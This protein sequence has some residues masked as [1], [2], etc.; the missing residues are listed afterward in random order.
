MREIPKYRRKRVG[1]N[2]K[3]LRKMPGALKTPAIPKAL[4]R[5]PHGAL[6]AQTE[7]ETETEGKQKPKGGCGGKTKTA[8]AG[9]RDRFARFW[10]AYPKKR[11]KGQAERAFFRIDPDEQFLATMIATI[12]RATTSEEWLKEGGKFIPYPATWLGARSWEDEMTAP[13]LDGVVSEVTARNLRAIRD[14]RSPS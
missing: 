9:V 12:E 8:N 4:L 2:Q 10:R 11:S 1:S 3:L 14:W 13:P 7:T 6:T 5:P